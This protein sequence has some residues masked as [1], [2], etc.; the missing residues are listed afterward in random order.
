MKPVPLKLKDGGPAFPRPASSFGNEIDWV[1]HHAQQGMTLRDYFAAEALRTYT[2]TD[3]GI[4]VINL[5]A[6]CYKIADAM[7]KERAK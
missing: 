2:V 7:L 4:N 6:Y 3:Q 1:N 5:A